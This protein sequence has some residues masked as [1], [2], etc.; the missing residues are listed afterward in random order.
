M[1]PLLLGVLIGA[2]AITSVATALPA[3]RDDLHLSDGE[4]LWLVDIYALALAAS[5]IVAARLG[6]AIGRKTTII[7]G[8]AGFTVLNAI[9]GFLENGLMLV[10]IRALLGVA[11][12]F[13]ISGVV[14]TI[15]AKFHAH[16]RVIAYGLWTATFGAGAALG[17][18]LGGLLAEGPGWR[19]LLLGSVPLAALALV[20]AIRLVPDSRSSIPP[21]WDAASILLSIIALG[22][23]AFAVHE[24]LASPV[25]AVVVA[26]VAAVSLTAFVFRQRR[27]REPLIDMAL[28][29]A[30]GFSPAIARIIVSSGASS[31]AVLLV[32]LQL[33]DAMGKSAAEAGFVLLP[34]AIA[35]AVG[36]VVAP[37]ALR[38]IRAGRL[39]VIALLVQAAGLAWLC[40]DLGLV[41]V[42]LVLVGIGYGITGTLAAAA[43]F[44]A[45]T[46]DQAGQ[47]GAVQEVGFALGGG[48]GMAVFGTL[49][50]V[51][52]V[53]GFV[54][55]IIAASVVVAAAAVLPL[56][57]SRRG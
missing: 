44:E 40:F 9:G 21:S 27:L 51:F 33:Q 11:E 2:L 8:L 25:L 52:V 22:A 24:A 12:A 41:A 47:V 34:Q 19:W 16:E 6:D 14:S 31:A 26:L 38:W 29:S 28:F 48:M 50:A 37:L 15:G 57:R 20:L 13:V 53:G 3:I 1:V 7:I 23:V 49:A 17:P 35:I 30:R 4:A 32:S 18:V 36:G 5:L 54:I 46:E 55:A 10:T 39:T 42:P 56:V 45:T 43:L